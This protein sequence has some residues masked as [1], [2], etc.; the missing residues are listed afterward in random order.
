MII[1]VME[2]LMMGVNARC[3]QTLK[4]KRLRVRLTF[5]LNRVKVFLDGV[6]G[7]LSL[8]AIAYNIFRTFEEAWW[9]QR[10]K[11][12]K[13]STPSTKNTQGGHHAEEVYQR[14][15]ESRTN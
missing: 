11:L 14:I 9:P 13:S 3:L 1:T 4:V 8:V 6:N 2:L 7:A 5:F 10:G 15:T 12:W